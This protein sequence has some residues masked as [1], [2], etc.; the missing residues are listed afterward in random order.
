MNKCASLEVR[1]PSE[2]CFQICLSSKG[3][4]GKVIFIIASA[5]FG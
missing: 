2:A 4:T 3:E 1:T 5:T